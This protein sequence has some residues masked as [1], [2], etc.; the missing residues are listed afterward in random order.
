[1]ADLACHPLPTLSI[2]RCPVGP[3]NSITA[4]DFRHAL[5]KLDQSTV[6]I[7]TVN[8]IIPRVR[9]IRDRQL[10]IS[11]GAEPHEIVF[12]RDLEEQCSRPSLPTI[13]KY[14]QKQLSPHTISLNARCHSRKLNKIVRTYSRKEKGSR[15]RAKENPLSTLSFVAAIDGIDECDSRTMPE[16]K[17]RRRDLADGLTLVRGWSP[18]SEMGASLSSSYFMLLESMKDL[19]SSH[20]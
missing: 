2:I 5:R 10:L 20:D 16:K 8:P 19:C 18:S 17:K 4:R 13:T 15:L 11:S 7:P 1:M 14:R 9:P 12:N 6:R 3:H